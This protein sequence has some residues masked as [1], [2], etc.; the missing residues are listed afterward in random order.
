MR[1][2]PVLKSDAVGIVAALKI[3]VGGDECGQR[4]SADELS[5]VNVD[6][7]LGVKAPAGSANWELNGSSC[8][9]RSRRRRMWTERGWR[10]RRRSR[11]N[12]RGCRLRT[13]YAVFQT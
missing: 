4:G 5:K 6:E 11:R 3:A 12:G 9:A 7:N 2:D 10:F 1:A 8:L 13:S